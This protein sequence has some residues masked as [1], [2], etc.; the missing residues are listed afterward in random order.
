M[1]KEDYQ[2]GDDAPLHRTESSDGDREAPVGDAGFEAPKNPRKPAQIAAFEKVRAK[3]AEN[4]AKKS[5]EKA[6][7]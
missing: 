5:R 1:S 4:L 6:R 3:R 2:A 7:P